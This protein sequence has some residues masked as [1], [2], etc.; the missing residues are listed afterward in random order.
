MPSSWEAVTSFSVSTP[1]SLSTT[2]IRV[3]IGTISSL[4]LPAS[5]AAAARSWLRTP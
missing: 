1:V 3:V 2:F 5:R 4:N